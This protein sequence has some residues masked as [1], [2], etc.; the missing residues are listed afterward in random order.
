M[1]LDFIRFLVWVSQ[2]KKPCFRFTTYTEIYST[3]H[4]STNAF[5]AK[6]GFSEAFQ[7]IE[8][9]YRLV[10]RPRFGNFSVTYLGPIIHLKNTPGKHNLLLIVF[11]SFY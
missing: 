1:I 6:Y 11:L 8:N 2:V 9:S 3:K 10:V 5:L 4:Y 7:L